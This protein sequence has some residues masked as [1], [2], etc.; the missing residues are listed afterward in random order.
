MLFNC[1]FRL[2]FRRIFYVAAAVS[3]FYTA[4]T[5]SRHQRG[6]RKDCGYPSLACHDT[7]PML[8]LSVVRR[9]VWRAE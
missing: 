6:A 7:A 1:V 3:R 2:L 8:A 5:L 4:K 9:A